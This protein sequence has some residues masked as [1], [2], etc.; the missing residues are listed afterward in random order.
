MKVGY[1]KPVSHSHQEEILHSIAVH[2]CLLTI[3]A[4]LDQL[5]D[6]LRTLGLLQSLERYPSLFETLFIAKNTSSMTAGND[7]LFSSTRVC[8]FAVIFIA[9]CA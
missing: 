7:I 6:G 2:H 4:E 9:A 1:T 5:R 3:K 8:L